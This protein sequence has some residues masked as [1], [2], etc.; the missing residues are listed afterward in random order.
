V[1]ATVEA[2]GPLM[3][4][5]EADAERLE[6]R[7]QERVDSG[8]VG[9]IVRARSDVFVVSQRLA[10]EHEAVRRLAGRDVVEVSDEMAVRFRDVQN[11]LA[12]LVDD[13]LALEYRLRDVLT[14][15]SG[16]SARRS[17]I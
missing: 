5:H 2:F 13:A 17:W 14:A 7:V 9:D 6:R 4:Q 3:Q 12:R 16:L 11:R 8:L 15:A 1:H 10:R